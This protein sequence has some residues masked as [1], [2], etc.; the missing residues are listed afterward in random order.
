MIT[1]VALDRAKVILESI[2]STAGQLE[3]FAKVLEVLTLLQDAPLP[4]GT[5]S[6]YQCGG[7]GS[8]PC[9]CS[10]GWLRRVEGHPC[11]ASDWKSYGSSQ[12]Y[13]VKQCCK[14]GRVFG[15]RYQ[16]DAGTGSDDHV[17]DFGFGDPLVLVTERHY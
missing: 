12:G 16:Y 8:A 11:N 1:Q 6:C 7:K 5:I 10:D 15:I 2:R 17:K 9:D 14:C 13:V 4:P 3:T